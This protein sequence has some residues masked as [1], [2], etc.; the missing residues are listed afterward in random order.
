MFRA[1]GLM[2]ARWWAS[3]QKA[4]AKLGYEYR[5]LDETLEDTIDWYTVLMRD[6]AFDEDGSSRMAMLAGGMRLGGRV[7]VFRALQAA[8]RRVGRRLVAGA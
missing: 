1:F 8:E 4:V 7:G 5:A 2:A 6:G 3:S